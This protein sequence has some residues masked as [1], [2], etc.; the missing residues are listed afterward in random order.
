[1][2]RETNPNEELEN[3]DVIE[4]DV[5]EEGS[6]DDVEDGDQGDPEMDL[7]T[8]LAELETA[9]RKLRDTNRESA[10]RRRKIKELEG[11]LKQFTEGDNDVNKK[12]VEV[13]Q[14]LKAAEEKVR[15]ND[16]RDK[17]DT[18]ATK[19]KVKW[20]NTAAQRDA[21]TFALPEI[22]ALGDEFEDADLKDILKDIVKDRP[23]L[24]FKPQVPDINSDRK[25][26]GDT[27]SQVDLDE[28]GLAFG[29]KS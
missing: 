18:I 11:Q 21:F 3:D 22:N 26:K 28:I 23:H 7:P 5:N 8:A 1:M 12:L 9:R 10:N 25:G 24:L 20:A 17:F 14:K 15:V 13:Q 19:E 4:E 29:I 6:E 16:L 27:L 2:G